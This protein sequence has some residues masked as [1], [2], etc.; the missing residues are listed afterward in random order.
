MRCN[1]CFSRLRDLVLDQGF[2]G[3]IIFIIVLPKPEHIPRQPPHLHGKGH[4]KNAALPKV[5]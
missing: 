2:D 4:S 3:N 5:A 1:W